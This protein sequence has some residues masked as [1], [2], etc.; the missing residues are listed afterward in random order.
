MRILIAGTT[1]YPA[2]NGQAVFTTNLAEGLAKRGHD[3]LVAFPSH[4]VHPSHEKC[5]GVQLEG[6]ESISLKI[7]HEDAYFSPFP[8]KPMRHIFET[9]QPD[10]VHIQD[11]YPLSD[12]V[13]R[14]AQR[15]KIKSVGTNHFMPENLAAYSGW[16]A[17]VK[18]VH[19][20]IGWTW[21]M[22]VYRRVDIATAQSRSAAELM[23]K[24]GL[25]VPVFPLSCGID[26]E[27]FYPNPQV[28]RVAC[29][30]RYGLDPNKKIFL[31]VGRVDAEKKLDVLLRAMCHVKCE[32]VQLVIAGRGAALGKLQSLAEKLNLGERVRFPGFIP[33]DDLTTLLN[34]VDVFVMPSEAELLSLA[35]LEAMACGRPVLL[36]NAVALPELATQGVNGYLFKPGDPVDAAKYMDLLASQPERWPAMG[37]AGL[38]RAQFHGLENTVGQYEVLYEKLLSGERL[39]EAL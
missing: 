23:R 38:E 19:R 18:P 21:M 20:W 6:I 8:R 7:L 17:R 28:D 15:Y 29:R 31:F 10:I 9:F 14:M 22:A 5:K 12:V 26:L 37:Q 27:H 33:T 11:H 1:Y 13:V 34:S 3:V 24:R 16:L 25:R 30:G 4:E 32:D 35:T 36:A 39:A 2:L